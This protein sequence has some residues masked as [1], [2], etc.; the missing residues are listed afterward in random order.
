M[1]WL[2]RQAGSFSSRL[3]RSELSNM[4]NWR[5]S[6]NLHGRRIVTVASKSAESDRFD[7]QWWIDGS[8][9]RYLFRVTRHSGSARHVGFREA[10]HLIELT[11]TKAHNNVILECSGFGE[12]LEMSRDRQG[13]GRTVPLCQCEVFS[14]QAAAYASP[15]HTA[16]P[17]TPEYGW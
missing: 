8:D 16:H 7:V 3:V 11:Q 4:A 15:L 9:Y 14:F 2:F 10:L 1:R 12:R 17:E 6:I 5:H 13:A